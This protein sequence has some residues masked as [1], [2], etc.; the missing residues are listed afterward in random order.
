MHDRAAA[1]AEA[2][3]AADAAEWEEFIASGGKSARERREALEQAGG[4]VNL[5]AAVAET[6]GYASVADHGV[7]AEVV[8]EN[9]DG[10]SQQCMAEKQIA[11]D[12]T[13]KVAVDAGPEENAAFMSDPTL[14]TEGGSKEFDLE[15]V[16]EAKN[17][18]VLKD[19]SGDTGLD[20]VAADIS[21]VDSAENRYNYIIEAGNSSFNSAIGVEQ[22]AKPEQKWEEPNFWQRMFPFILLPKGHPYLEEKRKYGNAYLKHSTEKLGK[23]FGLLLDNKFCKE[24]TL[25]MILEYFL[26]KTPKNKEKGLEEDDHNQK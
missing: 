16:D 24:Y 25:Q 18:S 2:K 11:I 26:L 17:E 19:S 15:I 8:S 3:A 9:E 13:P 6:P 4:A 23:G 14:K 1:K 12:D 10:S 20:G 5:M 21:L 22:T 7:A